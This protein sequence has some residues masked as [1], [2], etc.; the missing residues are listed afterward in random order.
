ML[1]VCHSFPG[2]DSSEPPTHI[3]FAMPCNKLLSFLGHGENHAEPGV[4][5]HHSPIGLFCFCQRQRFDHGANVAEYAEIKSVLGL[6]CSSCQTSDNRSATEN[7]GPAVDRD[8]ITRHSNHHEF[9]A[10]GETGKQATDRGSAWRGRQD[11]IG[12]S[13][14]LQC[15]RCILCLGVDVDMRPKFCREMLFVGAS[16]NRYRPKTHLSGILHSKVAK[17]SYSLDG[18]GVAGAPGVTECIK[19][20][21]AGAYQRGR[22]F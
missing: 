14:F 5:G 17:P 1:S 22:I 2:T 16:T 13:E 3:R 10:N 20:R 8:C 4:T 15:C 9:S 7:E 18:N 12:A 19:G 21:N 6:D 11:D